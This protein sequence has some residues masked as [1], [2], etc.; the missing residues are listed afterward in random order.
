MNKTNSTIC[1]FI[2]SLQ[3]PRSGAREQACKK[4]RNLEIVFFKKILND[5]V[6]VQISNQQ[7][8]MQ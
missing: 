4:Q 2:C 8:A 3:G 6:D 1:I 5:K 7:I